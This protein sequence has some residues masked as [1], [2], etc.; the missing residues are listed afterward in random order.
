[1]L[2]LKSTRS[3]LFKT[4]WHDKTE[5][6]WRFWNHIEEPNLVKSIRFSS[7]STE[8]INCQTVVLTVSHAVPIIGNL[9]KQ[10]QYSTVATCR[11]PEPNRL[12]RTFR[13]FEWSILDSE[14]QVNWNW[15]IN[16]TF[17]IYIGDILILHSFANSMF[18]DSIMRSKETR[19]RSFNC[20]DVGIF[21]FLLLLEMNLFVWCLHATKGPL[22]V[23]KKFPFYC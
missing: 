13:T 8:I 17:S 5:V 7:L 18:L 12:W 3:I 22:I 20:P 1:M 19:K 23:K 10:C 4:T 9:V 6:K 11:N 15:H 16:P 14:C 21:S 2:F